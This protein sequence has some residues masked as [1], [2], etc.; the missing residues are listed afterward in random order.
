V[1]EGG[2]WV[3]VGDE[4]T[5]IAAGEAAVWP[6]DIPH[7]AWTEHS[8]MR[9]IVVELAGVDDRDTVEGRGRAADTQ[10]RPVELGTGQLAPRSASPV[11]HTS[12][13]GE[14]A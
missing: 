2:G 13:E 4:Y 7:A 8:E 12:D 11:I 14:P 1:V 5:R 3:G 6:A 9:A 10:D